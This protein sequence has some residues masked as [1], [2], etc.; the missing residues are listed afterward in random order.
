MGEHWRPK[1]KLFLALPS[2]GSQ[3]GNTVPLLKAF[4][5][6]TSFHAVFPE[7]WCSSLLAHGFNALWTHALAER[8]NGLTHFLLL[9]AA[10]V[11]H[12]D[13]WFR[14]LHGEM[15]R[16]GAQVL[17]AVAPLKGPSGLTS[18]AIDGQP[19][20]RFT[21][22]EIMAQPETF[23]HPDLLINTGMLLVDMR[24]AWV[25]QICFT[26]KDRID[27][28][29]DGSYSVVCEPE[30][31]GFSRQARRLGVQLWATRKE[32]LIH[33]GPGYYNNF[34]EWGTET[35]DHEGLLARSGGPAV[36]ICPPLNRRPANPGEL[37]M[38]EEVS[39]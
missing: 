22:T 2:Y 9:H 25:E 35:R 1:L 15:V 33:M 10:I 18:T 14:Q 29:A 21:M 28:N 24:A 26:I 32:R 37:P 17:A 11:P 20:R 4:V 39:R 30:D 6:P 34:Q 3:R 23:T 38:T 8:K 36:G 27:K 19:L 16:V 12:D 13:D 5:G 31:W 7:E